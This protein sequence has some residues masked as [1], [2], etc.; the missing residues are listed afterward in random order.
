ME[1]GLEGY[2]PRTD[3]MYNLFVRLQRMTAAQWKVFPALFQQASTLWMLRR[4]ELF[5]GVTCADLIQLLR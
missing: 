1:D 3:L 4:L 2:Y 5:C